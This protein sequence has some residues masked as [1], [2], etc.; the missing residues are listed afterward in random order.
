M[1]N[2]NTPLHIESIESVVTSDKK[3]NHVLDIDYQKSSLEHLQK[4]SV[5]LDKI[6]KNLSYQNHLLYID[7]ILLAIVFFF[8]LI[9]RFFKIF[10]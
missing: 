8:T 5:T 2:A 4:I 7:T 3:I 1:I 10:I 9:Y 6:E